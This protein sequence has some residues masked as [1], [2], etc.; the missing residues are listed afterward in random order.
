MKT[1]PQ[2]AAALLLL[3]LFVLLSACQ[4]EP[5]QPPK[6][7]SA[8]YERTVPAAM[9]PAAADTQQAEKLSPAETSRSAILFSEVLPGLPGSNNHEFIELYNPG[10]DVVDLKGWSISY[11]TREELE[12]SVLFTWKERA[13][14]PANGH[15]LLARQGAELG[16][17]PDAVYDG[18][19]FEGKGGLILYDDEEGVSDRFGWG[20]APAAYYAGSPLVEF[21]KGDTLERLPGGEAGNGHDSGDNTADFLAHADARPQNSGSPLTPLDKERMAIS[22][23]Y[24]A[25]IPP[26]TEFDLLVNVENL[27][28]QSASQVLVS[29]PIANH[30]AAVKLPKGAE[31]EKG[32]LTWRIES[33]AAGERHADAL[34]LKTP[35][36][37]IDTAIRGYYVESENIPRAYGAHRLVKM[38]GSAI[39]IAAARALPEG[40]DVT[41]EGIVTMYPG[42]FFAGSSSAKFYVEDDTGGVQIFADDG[43][44]DV[45]VALGDLVHVS[46]RTALFRDS[47]EV[48]PEDNVADIIVVENDGPPPRAALI[49]IAENQA[50]DALLGR[51]NALEGAAVRIEEFNY[52][53]EIDLEDD[54]GHRALLYIEKDTGISVDPLQLGTRYRVTGI[55]ELA[56]GVRQLKPRLQSDI[57]EL[58]PP[59]LLLEVSGPANVRAGEVMTVTISTANHTPH[60]LTNV[61]VTAVLPNGLSEVWMIPELAGEGGSETVHTRL[62]VSEDAAGQIRLGRVTAVADQWPVPAAAPPFAAYIGEGVPI[63][64]IQGDGSRSP[65]IGEQVTTV[66]IVSGAFPELGGFFLQSLEPDRDSDTSDGIFVSTKNQGV[67]VH[68]GDV[69]EVNGRVREDEGQTILRPALPTDIV[70]RREDAQAAIEPVIYDP[71]RDSEQ[72]ER[73]KESLE[74]ML[75]TIDEPAVVVGPTN[76]YGEYVLVYDKWDTELIRRADGLPG[77]M[78]WVDDGTFNAHEDQSTLPVAAARGDR[79][80]SVSGPL[81]YTFGNYKIA[82]L[83]DPVVEVAERTMISLPEADGDQI[84]IATFNVENKFDA[85]IPHPDSPPKPTDE[86]YRRSLRKLAESIHLMGAPTI[87]ALQEVENL[88]VLQ[89][90]IAQPELSPYRYIPLLLES[91]DSR[92]IDQGYLVRGDRV[93]VEGHSLRDAPGELFSRPPSVLVATA[94]LDSGD[95]QLILLNNHFLSLSAGEAQTEPVRSGQAAWNAELVEEYRVAYPDAEIVVLGDLNSFYQTKP[96]DPLQET[97]LRHVY[98]L[99]GDAREAPYTYIF[100]G[101]AQTLDHMLVTEGLFQDLS[102][103]EALHIN[104]DYPLAD[105]GDNSPR[106]VSDHDPL[107]AMFA[108]SP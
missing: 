71:P 60:P 89:A 66:G 69:V 6:S 52:H 23:D 85:Q 93:T 78:M 54:E 2:R 22:L 43:R 33:I 108:L 3:F 65:L 82:P 8:A 56:S 24:P 7:T 17:I 34:T 21:V 37:N 63:W 58:F 32:R 28:S 5:A 20:E 35:H 86:A 105:P 27:S 94:H 44:F 42:G 4:R 25:A 29:L 77:Y 46:G 76:R 97:G 84:S 90:L 72:A 18:Q 12:P 106:R 16:I 31:M 70:L 79:V 74:G 50:D 103:V 11:Q 107:V 67:R 101:A 30:L 102:W 1:G 73:Y 91:K 96:L 40:S 57:V 68:A 64:A 62:L 81:A 95:Q 99:F 9:S 10:P 83:T 13:D 51:L 45:S 36:A 41:V 104:A 87:V 39:P 59:A 49:T 88:G 48:I 98:E 100:E 92:G 53:Y 55:S 80:R 47:L 75:V 14:I 19:M 26:D 61:V 38:D 15:Y